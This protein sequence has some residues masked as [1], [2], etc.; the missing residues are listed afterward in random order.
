MIIVKT[1][2]STHDAR[3]SLHRYVL[4]RRYILLRRYSRRH[5]P[6]A[7]PL[8]HLRRDGDPRPLDT[9]LV[10]VPRRVRPRV[11]RRTG[12][13]HRRKPLGGK[14]PLVRQRVGPPRVHGPAWEQDP[15]APR[16]PPAIQDVG[17]RRGARHDL[18]HAHVAEHLAANPGV[19]LQRLQVGRDDERA[20][21][22]VDA[23]LVKAKLGARL[24]EPR[25]LEVPV[26]VLPP[27]LQIRVGEG[28]HAGLVIDVDALAAKRV[29][30]QPD[31]PVE[32][33]GT[34]G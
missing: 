6:F 7:E 32:L 9:V 23:G 27:R 8:V 15:R 16:R 30:R 31:Q 10:G 14:L 33:G 28:L 20:L 19:K 2:K 5:G 24:P 29:L 18:A 21:R 3:S 25:P 22:S 12:D 17:P 34:R 13:G 26:A 1:S 4:L 11:M